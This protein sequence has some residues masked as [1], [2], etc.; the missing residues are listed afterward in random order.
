MFLYQIPQSIATAHHN[1]VHGPAGIN[2]VSFIKTAEQKHTY[3]YQQ[4]QYCRATGF[5]QSLYFPQ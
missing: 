2:A 3:N 4:Y 5:A 1:A